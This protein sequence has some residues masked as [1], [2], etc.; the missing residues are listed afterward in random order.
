MGPATSP[1]SRTLGQSAL[2]LVAPAEAG[3]AQDSG[4]GPPTPEK[5]ADA[6]AAVA[7]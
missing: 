3:P 6:E 7:R 5:K 1:L 4:N 2:D